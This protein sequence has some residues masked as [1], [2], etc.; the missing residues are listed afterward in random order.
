M[1]NANSHVPTLVLHCGEWNVRGEPRGAWMGYLDCLHNF[2]MTLSFS[3]IK[4]V[5]REKAKSRSGNRSPTRPG[6]GLS[7]WLGVVPPASRAVPGAPSALSRYVPRTAASGSAAGSWPVGGARETSLARAGW[8]APQEG[9]HPPAPSQQLRVSS[10]PQIRKLHRKRS[11]LASSPAP[12]S[13]HQDF[14]GNKL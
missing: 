10:C 13:P 7:V 2:S 9:L 8:A 6:A 5:K 12:Q 4:T 3:K 1:V 14:H 11:P